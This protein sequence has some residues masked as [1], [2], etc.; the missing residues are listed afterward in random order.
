MGVA[1]VRGLMAITFVSLASIATNTSKAFADYA[2]TKPAGPYVFTLKPDGQPEPFDVESSGWQDHQL[3]WI[4][5]CDGEPATAVG[6]SPGL[7]CDNRSSPAAAAATASGTVTFPAD[8]RNYAILPFE[9]ASPSGNFDCLTKNEI[10]S[11]AKE[12]TATDPTGKTYTYY[13]LSANDTKARDGVPLE[14]GTRAWTNCQL[15][16]ASNY[17]A[18]TNDQRFITL[19]F[20][21][22]HDPKQSSN[23]TLYVAIAVAFFGVIAAAGMVLVRRRRAAL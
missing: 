2:I 22:A 4:E 11:D 1:L 23:T 19:L 21:L 14:P 13:E 18:A 5:I 3:V 15:R 9:G 7:D 6:W 16:V 17:T 10:P 12:T 8:N 20:P